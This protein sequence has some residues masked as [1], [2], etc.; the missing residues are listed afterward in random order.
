MQKKA[1]LIY[2]FSIPVLPLWWL[3]VYYLY[4]LFID[5]TGYAI[6]PSGMG[7]I[8]AV[9]FIMIAPG[10][11]LMLLAYKIPKVLYLKCKKCDYAET[12]IMKKEKK[13]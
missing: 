11:F 5:K 10:Y 6:G 4:K 2:M 1:K 3:L 13:T 7:G 9:G 8:I 12:I